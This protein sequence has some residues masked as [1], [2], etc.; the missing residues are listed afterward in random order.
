MIRFKG[1]AISLFIVLLFMAIFIYPKLQSV[2][3]AIGECPPD[4]IEKAY[5]PNGNLREEQNYK[6]CQRDGIWREYYEN[7]QLQIEGNYK[8]GS[9]EGMLKYYEEDGNLRTE[10]NYKNGKLVLSKSFYENGTLRSISTYKNDKNIKYE[11]YSMHGNLIHREFRDTA[12]PLCSR[13]LKRSAE[14]K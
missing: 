9:L 2:C 3:F 14:P 5:Y 12:R 8:N 13:H 4:G 10:Q 11:E 7:G 6:D 1:K